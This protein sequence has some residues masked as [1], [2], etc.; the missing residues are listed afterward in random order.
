MK[1]GVTSE[2][3]RGRTAPALRNVEPATE[4]GVAPKQINWPV[5]VQSNLNYDPATEAKSATDAVLPAQW[6]NRLDGTVKV[7]TRMRV[8]RAATGR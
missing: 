1:G 8:V 2:G 6:S 5:R 4:T 3:R 7:R